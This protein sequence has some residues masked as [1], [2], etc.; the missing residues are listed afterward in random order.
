MSFVRFCSAEN[1]LLQRQGAQV[2]PK[3]SI[4][5]VFVKLINSIQSL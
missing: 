4:S 5:A 1:I 2:R 3:A